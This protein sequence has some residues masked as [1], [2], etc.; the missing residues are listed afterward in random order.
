MNKKKI[1]PMPWPPPNL[2]SPATSRSHASNIQRLK[3]EINSERKFE[4]LKKQRLIFII[5]H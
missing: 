5:F 3:I 4:K 2:C 1:L